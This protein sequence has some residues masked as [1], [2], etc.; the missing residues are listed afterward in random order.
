[1]LYGLMELN[2]PGFVGNF[3]VWKRG[4]SHGDNWGHGSELNQEIL[5]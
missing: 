5:P 2:R 3:L 4:L 1:M